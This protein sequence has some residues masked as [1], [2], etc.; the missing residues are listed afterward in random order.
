ME[1][2]PVVEVGH[3]VIARTRKTQQ[4]QEEKGL[5]LHNP[6]WLVKS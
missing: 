5:V 4:Q 6:Y 1:D 2:Q 3:A